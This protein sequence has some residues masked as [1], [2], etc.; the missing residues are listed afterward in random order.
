MLEY[1][2]EFDNIYELKRMM[3]RIELS[4]KIKWKK[5]APYYFIES[6]TGGGTR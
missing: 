6:V 1:H 4:D 2:Y 3:V 5:Y